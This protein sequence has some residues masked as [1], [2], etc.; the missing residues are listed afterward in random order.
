M[1][2]PQ[3]EGCVQ[4]GSPPAELCLS[5]CGLRCCSSQVRFM[6]D[7]LR[8]SD[9]RPASHAALLQGAQG[10]Q[11][12]GQGQQQRLGQGQQQQ[13]QQQQPGQPREA[14]GRMRVVWALRSTRAGFQ[15]EMLDA[16]QE[17]IPKETGAEVRA[18]AAAPLHLPPY[19]HGPCHMLASRSPPPRPR[20]YTPALARCRPR[21]VVA[22]EFG[23]LSM[24][25]QIR[26]VRQADVLAGY[27]GAA[28]TLAL[29]MSE[30]SGL[31]EVEGS[32]R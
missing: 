19:S 1:R 3:S 10:Q 17:R 13:Q 23:G 2:L 31:V 15:R 21:Q 18:A 6:L 22:V 7:G 30:P 16:L 29:Y 9:V 8:L 12:A 4:Q 11:Q 28:L 25:E 32:F 20:P 14:S 5:A 26:R 24:E 27:H